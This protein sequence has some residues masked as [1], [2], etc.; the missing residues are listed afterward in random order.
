MSATNTATVCVEGDCA[1][2]G[3]QVN[4]PLLE[5][6]AALVGAVSKLKV[7]VCAG[8]SASLAELVTSNVLPAMMVWLE[9]AD[10]TGG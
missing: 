2:V 3:R 10:S 5:L 1:M 9:I 6:M 4:K 7:K 8:M